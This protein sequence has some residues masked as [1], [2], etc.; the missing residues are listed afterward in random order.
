MNPESPFEIHPPCLIEGMDHDLYHSDPWGPTLSRSIAMALVDESPKHAYA[1]HPRLGN[2]MEEKATSAMG[3]GTTLHTLLLGA[4]QRLAI[5][6]FDSWRTNDAKAFR[7]SAVKD[8]ALPLLRKDYDKSSTAA[9][10]INWELLRQGIDISE[11]ASELSA[12][13][14]EEN[15][16]LCR[17]RWDL[18]DRDCT[19]YDFKIVNSADTGAFSRNSVK[20]YG[21]DIQEV[22]Y[23][24]ALE[25]VKP[26]KR[27]K[28]K[29]KFLLCEATPP[30]DCVQVDFGGVRRS[31]GE[32]RW[33]RATKLWKQ[34]LESGE[35][36][37][38]GAAGGITVEAK[39]WELEEEMESATAGITNPGWL[40]GEGE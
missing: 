33:R 38:R 13:W 35:W 10:K 30:Y 16:V 36:P 28:A 3:R 12:F 27:G 8:G 22:S 6:E 21:L 34:C 7:E 39:P 37:G 40:T 1:M 17:C 11:C 2:S 24:R 32:S 15:G 14:V 20:K 18:Y 9:D 25:A 19:I 29:L 5:A 26:E 31:I 4:G 23:V